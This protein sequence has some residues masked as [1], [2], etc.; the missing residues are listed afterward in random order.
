[1]YQH[2][3]RAFDPRNDPDLT[4]VWYAERTLLDIFQDDPSDV[5]AFIKECDSADLHQF[6]TIHGVQ[7]EIPIY[8]AILGHPKCDR[9]TALNIFAA[10]DPAYFDRK[11]AA[12]EKLDE[13]EDEEDHVFFQILMHAFTRLKSRETWRGRF[14]IKAAK[15]WAESP[16]T[17]PLNL[18]HL[19][20]TQTALRPTKNEPALSSIIYEYSEIALSFDAWRHRH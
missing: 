14:P 10:C 4:E 2:Q 5:V 13:L 11:I 9:A 18:K 6:D 3:R 15:K 19:K 20:L 17:Y 1:M 7:Q 8:A 16:Q 12:G